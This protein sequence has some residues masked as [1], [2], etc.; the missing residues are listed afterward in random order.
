MRY[1]ADLILLDWIKGTRRPFEDGK[2][3]ECL[4]EEY[5]GRKPARKPWWLR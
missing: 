4:F 2:S 3:A 1:L 5:L